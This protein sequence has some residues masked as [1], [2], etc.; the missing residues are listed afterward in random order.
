[1]NFVDFEPLVTLKSACIDGQCIRLTSFHEMLDVAHS[2]NIE[3]TQN[4]SYTVHL[5]LYY[6]A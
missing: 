4:L 1:M 3:H 2:L 6:V 5:Q